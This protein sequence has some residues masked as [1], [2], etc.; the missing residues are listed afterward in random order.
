MKHR[1]C[2]LA[3]IGLCLLIAQ[4]VPAAARPLRIVTSFPPSMIELYRKAFQQARPDIEVE[5]VQ[6]KTTAAVALI[7]G[8][9]RLEADLFW[10]SAPDAF[11]LLKLE[12]R[13]APLAPRDTG[14]PPVV[15]GYPVNDPSG[16]YLGFAL[17]GYGV[18][19]NEAY[20][21]RHGL[22]V[23][24]RWRDLTA[25]V[26]HGH[27]GISSP[28]RSGT[29]HLMVEALL[30]S[31][32]WETGWPVWRQVGGN[33][34]TVTARS[35]GVAAG[36]S[37]GR[38]GVGITIDFLAQPTELDAG[39]VRFSFPEQKVFTPASI[40]LLKDAENREAANAFVDF[41]LSV[42][43]QRLLL[44]PKIDRQP[45]RP[46]FYAD[47]ATDGPNP[48]ALSDE[49]A[50]W[51]FDAGRSAQRYELINILFDEL[52]TFP[53]SEA[54]EIWRTIYEVE[55]ALL[56][57]PDTDAAREVTRAR[58]LLAQMPFGETEA[59]RLASAVKLVRV[60]RGLPASAEQTA[61][62][63]RI[64]AWTAQNLG[65]ARAAAEA[66]RRHLVD[67]GRLPALRSGKAAP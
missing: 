6:R 52:I 59:A 16:M 21:A 35:F 5:F 23:P 47:G 43:G 56:A 60:P 26:Y 18:V 7:T 15:A 64:Q 19:W 36:V 37:R 25:P 22:S 3:L 57:A 40:A 55:A 54:A 13:L 32:G 2:A 1:I 42:Q 8:G 27:V 63:A 45:I 39:P 34:A 17:S 65:E 38:F 66:G 11:E 29:T 33:L 12:G 51:S 58:A 30:Q 31:E 44:D 14:T 62:T 20:L 28:S 4:A 67:R 10:A 9:E 48:F 24:Q 49:A 61:L 41:L 46:E 50:T 53:L